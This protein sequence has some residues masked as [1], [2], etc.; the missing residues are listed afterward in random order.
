MIRILHIIAGTVGLY[1]TIPT[2]S[3]SQTTANH[4]WPCYYR[5][6]NSHALRV[7]HT[8]QIVCLTH[9]FPSQAL[10]LLEN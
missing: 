5:H 3:I 6:V 8:H 2:N 10:Q 4:H 1:Y 7:R 9:G